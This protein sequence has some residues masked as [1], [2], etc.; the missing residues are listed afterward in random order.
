MIYGHIENK[1][2]IKAGKSI[3]II[4]QLRVNNQ[5]FTSRFSLQQQQKKFFDFY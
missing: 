3:T 4:I 1:N 5:I 2:K